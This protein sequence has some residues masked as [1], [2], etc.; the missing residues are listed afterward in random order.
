MLTVTEI[1]KFLN[2]FLNDNDSTDKEVLEKE[3]LIFMNYMDLDRNGSISKA[4]FLT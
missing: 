3:L 4:E 2:S 1:F